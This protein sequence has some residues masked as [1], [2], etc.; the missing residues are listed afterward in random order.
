M[1]LGLKRGIVKL[2]YFNPVWIKEYKKEEKFLKM[3][4]GDNIVSIEHF[5]STSIEGM[6]SKPIIDILVGVKS[7]KNEGRVCLN[8]LKKFPKYFQR[9][10][11]FSPKNRL[12]I[13]KG[14]D[15]NRTHYIHI[16][17]YNGRVWKDRLFFRDYLRKDKIKFDQYQRLKEVLSENN[18]N[19]RKKYTLAK[20]KF[21]KEIIKKQK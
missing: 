13:A 6:P 10:K 2:N 9:E 12:L 8:I 20:N 15:K 21:V 4:L 17:R 16:V 5:G 11:Y 1:K 18:L 19:D 3:V 14:N 7:V